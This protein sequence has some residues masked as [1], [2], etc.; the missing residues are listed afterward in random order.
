MLDTID[1]I[2]VGRTHESLK[3]VNK[4]QQQDR[5]CWRVGAINIVRWLYH[6]HFLF[7]YFSPLTKRKRK[8]TE[9][10][11]MPNQKEFNI[12]KYTAYI[13]FYENI[14]LKTLEEC[15]RR[16]KRNERKLCKWRLLRDNVLKSWL[17]LRINVRRW[18]QIRNYIIWIKIDIKIVSLLLSMWK[19][20]NLVP[21][22]SSLNYICFFYDFSVFFVFRFIF[23][24]IVFIFTFCFFL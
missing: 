24:F 19:F 6:F 8:E 10:L 5:K 4:N 13:Y 18:T 20:S 14:T 3:D 9:V 16:V 7:I 21:S 1:S 22:V 12:R 2:M 17:L 23:L 15:H 11:R